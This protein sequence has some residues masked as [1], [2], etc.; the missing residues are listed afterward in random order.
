MDFVR[1][2]FYD[3]SE[4]V[5]LQRFSKVLI[6][7]DKGTHGR[8]EGSIFLT[9]AVE[10]ITATPGNGMGRFLPPRMYDR[11]FGEANEAAIKR[12]RKSVSSR[13]KRQ[14]YETAIIW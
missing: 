9:T 6:P 4:K 5:Y 2:D 3:T 13:Q 1:I 12:S 11:L 8:Y 7:Q 14:F 10:E